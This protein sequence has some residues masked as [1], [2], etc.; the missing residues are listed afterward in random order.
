MCLETTEGSLFREIIHLD[1][2]NPDRLVREELHNSVTV[3]DGAL[4]AFA[5]LII[6]IL[7]CLLFGNID[8]HPRFYNTP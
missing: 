1:C 3:T 4:S 8:F 7:H 2:R 5:Q 6:V